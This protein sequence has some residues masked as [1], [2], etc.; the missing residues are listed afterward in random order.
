MKNRLLTL[1]AVM[2]ALGTALPAVAQV[3]PRPVPARPASVA[4][5]VDVQLMVV[6]ANNEH[7]RVDARLGDLRAHLRHM[8]Y[9]GYDVLQTQN[10]SLTDGQE[11][12]YAVAGSR[13][14]KVELVDHDGENAR[15]RIRMF[16]G[17][18]KVLDTT[19]SVRRNRS[20]IVMG[21]SHNDGV[22]ILPITVSY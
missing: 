21:P 9:T 2:V 1:L 7:D 12:R 22:L 4:R 5:A 3:P 19:V 11:A 15:L 13:E 6:H 16:T 8:S 10:E 17:D 20:F 14:I 18:R